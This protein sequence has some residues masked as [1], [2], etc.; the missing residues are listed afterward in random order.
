MIIQLKE[1][2]LEVLAEEERQLSKEEATEFY[3]QHEG[4]VSQHSHP[5]TLIS[6]FLHTYILQDYFEELIEFMSR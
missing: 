3:K 6:P 1:Q 2:G 5:L 4:T